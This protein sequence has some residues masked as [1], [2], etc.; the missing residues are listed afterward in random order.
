VTRMPDGGFV[1]RGRVDDQLSINGHRVETGEIE[2]ALLTDGDVS[3]L[4]VLAEPT[5]AGPLLICFFIMPHDANDDRLAKI[6]RNL[7]Q[8]AKDR[9]PAYMRPNK[10]IPVSVIKRTVNGKVDK[11]DLFERLRLRRNPATSNESEPA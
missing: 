7:R 6:R 8:V 3:D 4:S 2:S 1:Y 9:L 5:E 11:D 10:Y